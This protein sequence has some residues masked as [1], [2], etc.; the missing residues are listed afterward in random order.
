MYYFSLKGEDKVSHY[1]IIVLGVSTLG[2]LLWW[3]YKY[4]SGKDKDDVEGTYVR[5]HY[6]CSSY[7]VCVYMCECAYV[8]MYAH[9]H[10]TMILCTHYT[11]HSAVPLSSTKSSKKYVIVCMTCTYIYMLVCMYVLNLHIKPL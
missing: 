8:C 2:I 3:L 9:T 5:I 4:F 10:I 7:G 11:A 1:S 6:I